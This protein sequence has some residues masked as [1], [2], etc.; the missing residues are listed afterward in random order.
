MYQSY[1]STKWP[2]VPATMLMLRRGRSAD[3]SGSS[4]GSLLPKASFEV[5]IE[6][7]IFSRLLG[8]GIGI[9]GT[10]A[11]TWQRSCPPVPRSKVLLTSSSGEADAAALAGNE[12]G[13]SNCH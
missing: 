5:V 6:L 11:T 12:I 8:R 13:C 4:E 1:H 2:I 9:F 7:S 10:T 3:T